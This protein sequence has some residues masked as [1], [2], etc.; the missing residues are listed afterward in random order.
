MNAVSKNRLHLLF[1]GKRPGVVNKQRDSTWLIDRL[2]K[3]SSNKARLNVPG[4]EDIRW[5]RAEP[6]IEQTDKAVGVLGQET[7]V[8]GDD[9]AAGVRTEDDAA[10][11]ERDNKA[12]TR[13][14]NN[15][16]GDLGWDDYPAGVEQDNEV[17][18]K[19]DINR[20]SIPER[21]HKKAVEPEAGA[22]TGAQELSHYGFLLA[23][24]S[25]SFFIFS[26]SK[27]VIDW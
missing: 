18:T 11:I 24:H 6:N 5:F 19:R 1:S 15:E 2:G 20:M 12:G 4:A 9:P 16:V 17:E 14:D 10:D 7:K 27:S 13:Q 8:G 21:V 3:G 22:R 26:S 25:N 23:V